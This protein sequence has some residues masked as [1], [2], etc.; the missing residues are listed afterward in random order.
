MTRDQTARHQAAQVVAELALLASS[1]VGAAALSRMVAAPGVPWRVLAT[2]AAGGTVAL[3][4]GRRWWPAPVAAAVPVAVVAVVAT[5]VSAW[6]ATT[7][8][9]PTARTWHAITMG[10]RSAHV[11][12]A[13]SNPPYRAVGGITLVAAITAGGAAVAARLLA[14]TSVGSPLA[15]L[16]P[17]FALVGL[18]AF[19]V[20]GAVAV[21]MAALVVTATVLLAASGAPRSRELAGSAVAVGVG[22]AV[23]AAGN[24][25]GGPFASYRPPPHPAG[26][27]STAGGASGGSGVVTSLA[28][29][30]SVD[31]VERSQPDVVVFDAFVAKPT[32]WQVAVLDTFNGTS[33]LPSAGVAALLRGTLPEPPAVDSAGQDVPSGSVALQAYGSRLLP[34]PPGTTAVSGL[35]G[36]EV[37]PFGT[38][39]PTIP[40]RGDTYTTFTGSAPTTAGTP[41]S[42]PASP[43]SDLSLPPLPPEV[44]ALAHQVTAGATSPADEA[45]RLTA[46]FRS[47]RFTYT[48]VPPHVPRG[49]DPLVAF[50]T[51]TRSGSCQQF[52]TAFA[53]MARTLGLPARVAVGFAPGTT[54]GSTTVV[55]GADA[56]AWPEVYLGPATGWT[57]FEPTPQLPGGA[58]VPPSVRTGGALPPGGGIGPAVTTTLPPATTTTVTPPSTAQPPS[59]T[60]A[61][62]VG[63]SRRAGTLASARTATPTILAVL[64]V[65]ALVVVAS[66]L[67]LARRRRHRRRRSPEERIRRS[68]TRAERALAGAGWTRPPGEPPTAF[69]ERLARATGAV[70]GRVMLPGELDAAGAAGDL[71]GALERATFAAGAATADD[72]DRAEAAVTDLL[73]ALRL[74]GTRAALRD[75]ART[76]EGS[77]QRGDD[78][79]DARAGLSTA[80]TR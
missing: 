73:V 6:G 37:T 35:T 15:A 68:W 59:T 76:P 40:I 47:G 55:T 65:L 61:P 16:A 21:P 74:P 19:A 69:A 49:S 44:S 64:T 28:L 38:A 71:A 9:I 27:G 45:A 12:I 66:G 5:W 14:G 41:S 10:L 3:V 78:A 58:T 53:A 72:A 13:T 80:A 4:G 11:V 23:L 18:S 57:S 48:L 39:V 20:G 34:V 52:A 70:A 67:E 29:V 1:L 8:G 42:P 24:A 33:W 26:R 54:I 56:H 32:Y 75:A 62:A 25:W 79:V 17:P 60:T 63:G 30:A 51:T 2:A 50:L 46:W 77:G 36:I 22:V 31:A 7:D 43:T